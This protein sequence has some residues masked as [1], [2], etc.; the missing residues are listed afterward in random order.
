[1]PNLQHDATLR[2]AARAI[3]NEVYPSDEWAPYSFEEAERYA[4]VQYRQAVS[5]A[6]MAKAALAVPGVQLSLPV[7]V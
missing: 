3:Y 2:D 6:Q 4:T 7:M 5:A 1:M